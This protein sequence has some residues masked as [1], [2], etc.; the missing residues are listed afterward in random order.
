MH[1]CKPALFQLKTQ[2]FCHSNERFSKNVIVVETSYQISDVLSLCKQERNF[3]WLSIFLEKYYAKT[4][5]SASISPIIRPLLQQMLQFPLH[6][7]FKKAGFKHDLYI[8]VLFSLF[9][10]QLIKGSRTAGLVHLQ[11]E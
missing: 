4:Y 7:S 9:P 6:L 1:A 11:K 10:I 5:L 8:I 2:S 3:L